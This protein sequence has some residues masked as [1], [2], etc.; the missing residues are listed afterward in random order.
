MATAT[1]LQLSDTHFTESPTATVKGRDPAARLDSVLSAWRALGSHVDLL[2][3]TGD[4]ADDGSFEGCRRLAE[5]V[6]RLDVPILA[7]SGNHDLASE[8]AAVF[9]A[10]A[11]AEVGAWRVVGLESER[12]G[13]IEGMLDVPAALDHLDQLDSRPTVLAV[14]H[15]PIGTS[16]HPWFQLA[17]AEELLAGLEER[18][19]VRAIISGH[20][21]EAFQFAGAGG[22]A[23]LGAPSTVYAI[24]HEGD[25]WQDA[26]DGLTGA[27]ILRLADDGTLT[28]ELLAA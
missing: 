9:G 27:R 23:L 5:A 1:V 11:H 19:H 13:A 26:E 24:R 2:V 10:G 25:T 15:P 3:L 21:H 17:G 22:L 28:T 6:K 12:P 14:H 18:P 20:L 16:T 8:V 4:N 7:V